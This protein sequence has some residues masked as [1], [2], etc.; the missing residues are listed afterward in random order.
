MQNKGLIST[1]LEEACRRGKAVVAEI[2][3]EL[4]IWIAQDV[5]GLTK[6]REGKC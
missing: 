6:S 3:K 4:T 2:V 5:T 1:R